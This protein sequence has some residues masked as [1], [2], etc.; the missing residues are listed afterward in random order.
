MD[1]S[2]PSGVDVSRPSVAR[3]VYLAFLNLIELVE[4]KLS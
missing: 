3:M 2:P 1:P 4:F